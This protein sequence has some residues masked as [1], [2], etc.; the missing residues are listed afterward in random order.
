MKKI[1]N[2]K[3]YDTETAVLIAEMDNGRSESDF[4][5]V[6]EKMFLKKTGEFF[7]FGEGGA[8]TAYR[9]SCDGNSYCGGE[10]LVPIT[11]DEAKKFGEEN[12]SAEAYE[13]TFGVVPE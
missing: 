13:K 10:K 4:N 11:T 6:H 5:W 12:M 7:L 2:G 1:I 9:R 8:M 3:K